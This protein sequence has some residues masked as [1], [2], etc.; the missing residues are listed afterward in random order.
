M[1]RHLLKS[2]FAA[3]MIFFAV[4]T[5]KAA[6]QTVSIN[7]L[8]NAVAVET[9]LQKA[10]NAAGDN[11]I[12]TVT[13]TTSWTTDG[14]SITLAIPKDVSLLWTAS[15]TGSTTSGTP[16][17]AITGGNIEVPTDGLI[18]QARYNSIAIS[19][20]SN[21]TISG[22]TVNAH[23]GNSAILA[24]GESSVV[25]VNSGAVNNTIRVTG[26]NGAITVSGGTVTSGTFE[27]TIQ[28]NGTNSTVTVAGG[29]VNH[30]GTGY[31]INTEGESSSII[32]SGGQVNYQISSI[33]NSS[34][35]IVS[36][37][38]KSSRIY[39]K[40]N[41]EI[42][43]NAR[44]SAT[45]TN[46]A[47]YVAGQRGVVTVSGGTVNATQGRAIA[48]EDTDGVVHVS[49]GTISTDSGTT[50][51]AMGSN[52]TVIVS[53]GKI[54]KST[55][56]SYTTGAI[57]AANIEVKGDAEITYEK[58]AAI[59]AKGNVTISGGTLRG[60]NSGTIDVS[61][62]NSKVSVSGG[63]VSSS[64]RGIYT[65]GTGSTVTISGNGKVEGGFYGE[66]IWA[67]GNVEVKENAEVNAFSGNNAIFSR[68][69]TI[70][71]SGGTVFSSGQA[72]RMNST[73]SNIIVSGG[74]VNSTWR[75]I[76]NTGTNGKVSITGGMVTATTGYA[77]LVTDANSRITISGGVV[78]AYEP[79][80][81]IKEESNFTGVSGTGIVIAW[82]QEAGNTSYVK[83]TINDLSMLPLGCA[84][85][86]KVS[87]DGGIAYEN[88]TN[89][90]FIALEDITIAEGSGITAPQTEL[91][92]I[93]PNPVTTELYIQLATQE[94][95]DYSIYNNA[96]H[97][98]MR[99][100]LQNE[101]IINVQS[102]SNGIYYMKIIG[103]ENTVMKFNINHGS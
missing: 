39:S 93:Y 7:G 47:I 13:G 34:T 60:G 90:G 68:G 11:G 98:V 69:A 14:A 44:V 27:G 84:K 81:S 89:K 40:G 41:V 54:I 32:I 80:I 62:T 49:G 20:D 37:N 70:I 86:D 8:T 61:G 48:M 15:L 23:I 78:F 55:T 30:T 17:L 85:W 95:V 6:D 4:F 59:T 88:G 52:S 99:G 38:G 42:K 77:I 12:V 5:V 3:I 56:T 72:I 82:N 46:S 31:A 75:A 71:V 29:Q 65:S 67:A 92:K 50:I 19:T 18:A 79:V 35:V 21:V 45:G 100:K 64:G 73:N 57:S 96:G 97:V 36:G 22:G 28:A 9:A 87:E 58:G 2:I 53:G 25:T 66:T 26:K 10:I 51:D 33:G 43:D 24:T 102:L 83:G 91:L 103:K 94:T 74:K 1:N 101:S 63:T 16:L 76:E